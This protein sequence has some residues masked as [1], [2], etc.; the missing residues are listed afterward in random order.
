MHVASCSRQGCHRGDIGPDTGL[1]ASERGRTYR[2]HLGFVGTT[3]RDA[4]Q[5]CDRAGQQRTSA[6]TTLGVDGRRPFTHGALDGIHDVGHLMANGFERGS[7]YLRP[8]GMS[9][10]SGDEVP[11]GD[12]SPVV[13]TCYGN[14]VKV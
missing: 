6:G 2:G 8:A 5:V 9:G 4:G 3:Q 13:G 1:Y 12:R 7:S 11:P 10:E 14:A